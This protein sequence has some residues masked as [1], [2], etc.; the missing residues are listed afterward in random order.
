M[1]Y[2][3]KIAYRISDEI[4]AKKE[5]EKPFW[6]EHLHPEVKDQ[7]IEEIEKGIL[8]AGTPAE[9]L[10]EMTKH[11]K[12][13]AVSEGCYV[14][15][16]KESFRV[17]QELESLK[18]DVERNKASF[19]SHANPNI[20][21]VQE[22][23]E[24]IPFGNPTPKQVDPLA[25]PS[26]IPPSTISPNESGFTIPGEPSSPS[27]PK[28]NDPLSLDDDHL[29]IM[30]ANVKDSDLKDDEDKPF[31]GSLAGNSSSTPGKAELR[32]YA[33]SIVSKTVSD[34]NA[35]AD[36]IPDDVAIMKEQELLQAVIDELKSLK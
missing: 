19:V 17:S 22:T 15:D 36:G 14:I 32:K 28:N 24:P 8:E 1:Y 10:A 13:L 27:M 9:K 6:W 35:K 5:A 18:K 33:Q 20:Q 26:A 30:A 7:T 31:G 34:I 16:S 3:Y 12:F 21:Q 4:I 23:Y 29:K 25:L 11:E 2:I